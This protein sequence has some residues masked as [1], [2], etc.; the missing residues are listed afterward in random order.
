MS[1]SNPQLTALHNI[2]A[3]IQSAGLS[4][5]DLS[6]IALSPSPSPPAPSID[7]DQDRKSAPMVHSLAE[8]SQHPTFTALRYIPPQ[9]RF[10]SLCEIRQGL[11][12]INR[13]TSASAV[14]EHPTGAIV[15]YPQTGA[16]PGQ[17]IAHI[18]NVDPTTFSPAYHP[19][20]SFQYSL[21]DGHGGHQSVQCLM[22][23]DEQ[24][25][26][27]QCQVLKTSC[28][29][30]KICSARI[31]DEAHH[32]FT[33][34]E[35]ISA[36][37][38]QSSSRSSDHS[39]EKEV[40]MKTLGFFCAL[41]EKGCPFASDDISASV[42]GRTHDSPSDATGNDDGRSN[43][44]V[45]C[46]Q[47]IDNIDVVV[48]GGS[49]RLSRRPNVKHCQGKLVMEN[50]KYNQPFIRLQE[51]DTR[52][53]RALLEDDWQTINGCERTAKRDGYAH[54]PN[55]NYVLT[56][57]VALI[58]TSNEEHCE[59]GCREPNAPPTTIFM[60]HTTSMCAPGFSFSV[61]TSLASPPMPIKTPPPIKL[62]FY[63]LLSLMKWKLADATPRRIFLD[64]AFV[65][66]LQQAQGWDSH[67][68]GRDATLHDLHPSF[69]NHDHVQRLINARRAEH[70]P[71]GTG[72]DGEISCRGLPACAH[73][74]TQEH[75]MLPLE[76]RYVRCAEI[77]AIGR[78]TELKLVI[79]M[80][81]RM[82]SQLMQAKRLSI[83]T[84]F[85]RA[86]GWQEFE[87]ESWD[88]ECKR[89]VVGARTFTTSQTAKAHLI[90]FQRIFEIATADTGIQ[91]RFRHI[92]GD[93]IE[94]VVA[95]SHKGQ[96]LGL[97]MFCIEISRNVKTPCTYEPHHLI[98]E[99]TPYEHLR[100]FYRLCVA[101]FKR[102][103][104]SL[105][106]IVSK[107]VYSAMMSLATSE[108]HPDIQAT[109]N[110]IRNGG[111]KAAAWLKDKIDSTKFALPALYQ[112]ESLIP[113]IIW[114][115]CPST[116]NGNEQAHRNAYR[117]GVNLTL[118]AGI[119]KG[120]KYDQ[121]A[122][123]SIDT[124]STF[125]IMTR[126]TD[127]THAFRAARAVSRKGKKCHTRQALQRSLY[128]Q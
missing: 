60:F 88:S 109:L 42:S 22:L 117:D 97:G 94:S 125:G 43:E 53:L 63:E 90:L 4:P 110:C 76:Q 35:E 30:L 32:H 101:H 98:S 48:D 91:V 81:A 59:N 80:T 18:F 54:Q 72:F 70:Y 122:M 67:M 105:K 84:S 124:H 13:K 92:H 15:E 96:G 27:V 28:K 17:G 34:H 49:S 39:A 118:L 99:L 3:L 61:K 58:T 115:A 89:S 36:Q 37:L 74:I 25:W 85:K 41:Q 2:Q 77:H 106:G 6:H 111:P 7:D 5:H 21:G 127:A 123:V 50:D 83:D 116:T 79:C 95:D 11:N 51:Y 55:P 46:T 40:F 103:I 1:L 107:E 71:C 10:Y 126:D 113:S 14:V 33:N 57:T 12:R 56:G 87:I 69:A 62:L 66:S 20:A 64:T 16:I 29:G 8:C 26:P 82:S 31:R 38:L 121:A 9:A 108:Q 100:R 65:E 47:Y 104:H 86:Q 112:P 73:L 44:G 52:Y 68:K 45:S 93:G 78:G 23:R 19:K 119:M 24:G 114:K 102:N 120:M 75:A 128:H